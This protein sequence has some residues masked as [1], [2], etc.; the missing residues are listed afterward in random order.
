MVAEILRMDVE[1]HPIHVHVQCLK[2]AQSSV[3]VCDGYSQKFGV[4]SWCL[5]GID[6]ESAAL[7]CNSLSL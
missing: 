7:T 2:G 3:I 1:S 6:P 5:S 4:G